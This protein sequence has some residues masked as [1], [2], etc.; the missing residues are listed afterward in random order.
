MCPLESNN[1]EKLMSRYRR[2]PTTR[3]PKHVPQQPTDASDAFEFSLQK[4]IPHNCPRVTG[5]ADLCSVLLSTGWKGCVC[6]FLL[7]QPTGV[8]ASGESCPLDF[9]PEAFYTAV[10]R[11][12]RTSSL[13]ISVSCAE[14]ESHFGI[15]VKQDRDHLW[16]YTGVD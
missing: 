13:D 12:K 15:V 4:L 3:S 1:G 16:D 10:F 5:K 7:L 11:R 6:V 8:E 2:K 14:I 9:T